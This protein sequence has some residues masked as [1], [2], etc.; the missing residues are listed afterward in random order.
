MPSQ[1]IYIVATL[2]MIDLTDWIG[3]DDDNDTMWMVATMWRMVGNK[4][5]D[6]LLSLFQIN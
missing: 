4:E 5:E 1:F 2:K 6:F 3:D